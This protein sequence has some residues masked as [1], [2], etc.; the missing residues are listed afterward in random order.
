MRRAK[1]SCGKAKKWINESVDGNLSSEQT[2]QLEAHVHGCDSCRKLRD[3]FAAIS[4]DA[5]NLEKKTPSENV[6]NRI[7]K[8]MTTDRIVEHSPRPRKAWSLSLSP[9][10]RPV[11][12]S[13]FA[14]ILILAAVFFGLRQFGTQ[15][16]NGG[17]DPSQQ[18]ALSKLK[19]AEGHYR[20]AI[21]ALS[22]AVTAREADFDPQILAVFQK[23]LTVVNQSIEACRQAVLSDPNDFDSRSYLLAIYQDKTDLLN[24]LMALNDRSPQI[25][26]TGTTI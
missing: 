23:N 3:D 9:G 26:K 22:A 25:I 4:K 21:E 20:M 8:S 11:L 12:A 24:E 14:L 7:Q 13:S 10:L 1:L 17:L 16:A 2:Q 19:E 6:W 18:F 5:G 15:P